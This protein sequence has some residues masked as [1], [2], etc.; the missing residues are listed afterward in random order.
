MISYCAGDF[1]P[2]HPKKY[3]KKKKERKKERGATW[4]IIQSKLGLSTNMVY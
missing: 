1:L 3:E 4:F 2:H